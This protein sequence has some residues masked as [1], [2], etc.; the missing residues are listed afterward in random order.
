MENNL[1]NKKGAFRFTYF[2][3]LY[4]ETCEFY[5][6]QLEFNLEHFWDR[7]EN[8]KGSLFNAGVGLIE[9]LKFPESEDLFNI[10]LDYRESQGVFMVIQIWDIDELFEKYKKKGIN[11]KQE[12]TNQSW[13][14]RSFSVIDPNGIIILYIQDIV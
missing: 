5:A 9:I 13:G 3:K 1:N 12:I 8:D 4:I 14:H 10:G 2:T 11:F 7:S 6:N